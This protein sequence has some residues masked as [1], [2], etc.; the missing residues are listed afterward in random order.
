MMRK[1]GNA[2][3]SILRAKDQ[4]GAGDRVLRTSFWLSSP[5]R[6]CAEPIVLEAFRARREQSGT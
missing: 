5:T 6:G 1:T 3:A 4:D 2:I